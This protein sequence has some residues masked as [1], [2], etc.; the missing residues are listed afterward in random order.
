MKFFTVHTLM[1]LATTAFAGTLPQLPAKWI[2]VETQLIKVDNLN[3][4]LAKRSGTE[5]VTCYNKG[6]AID[7]G[8]AASV[9]DDFCNNRAIG[10]TLTS[11][12]ILESRYNYGAFTVLVSGAAINGCNFQVDG[13]CNRLLRLPLDGCNTGGVNGKQGGYETDL[14]GQWRFDPGSNGSDF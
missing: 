11:G 7:R 14:C 4:T 2:S 9:I 5:S 12:H 13:N 1:A 6:T 3:T 8:P 10:Q